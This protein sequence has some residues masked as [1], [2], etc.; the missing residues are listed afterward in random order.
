MIHGFSMK[1]AHATPVGHLHTPGHQV[2]HRKNPSP[3]HQPLILL[4]G[5]LFLYNKLKL[6]LLPQNLLVLSSSFLKEFYFSFQLFHF[7]QGDMEQL[8]HVLF[9]F[10]SKIPYTFDSY[11]QHLSILTLLISYL[12]NF[13]LPK[14][15]LQLITHS[16]ASSSV[17]ST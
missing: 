2:V 3:R 13:R 15:V 4:H 6:Q 12:I 16:K 9:H 5:Y 17:L 1:V 7:V 11:S 14:Y 8:S 10:V